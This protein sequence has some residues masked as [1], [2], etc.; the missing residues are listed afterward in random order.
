MCI[1]DRYE[2][3]I[4]IAEGPFEDVDGT[5]TH[6]GEIVLGKAS[7]AQVFKRELHSIR[8]DLHI[9]VIKLAREVVRHT[10]KLIVGLGQGALV[11]IAEGPFEDFDGTSTHF[12]E[13]V[14]GK[15]TATQILKREIHQIRV[16]LHISVV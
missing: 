10:P 6:F 12:G 14:L 9:S 3:S 5:S 2:V 15:A 4:A 1:R 16:D 8:V 11:A 7:K 13:L